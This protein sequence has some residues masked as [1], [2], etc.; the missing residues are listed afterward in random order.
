MSTRPEPR[1]NAAGEE[2]DE[3]AAYQ[4]FILRHGIAADRESFA[5]DDAERPLT[6]KGRKRMARIAAELAKLGYDFDWIVTSPLIRAAETAEIVA[7]SLKPGPPVDVCAAL[8]PGGG[9]EDVLA[10]LAKNPER[11]SVMLVGHEPD[12]SR[13]AARLIGAGRDANL[14]LK[15][16]GCCLIEYADLPA[17]NTGKLVWWLTPRTLRATR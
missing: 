13:H 15:K 2:Q 12:L 10:L 8:R 9:L 4:L 11:R 7:S 5:G 1:K 14:E 3:R 6:P 16:G 17:R